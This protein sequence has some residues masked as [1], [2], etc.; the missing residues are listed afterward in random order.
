MIRLRK[1]AGGHCQGMD[2]Q[3]D[4]LRYLFRPMLGYDRKDIFHVMKPCKLH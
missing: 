3:E 4:D 2:S 1:G